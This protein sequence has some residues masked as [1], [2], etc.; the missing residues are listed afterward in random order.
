LPKQYNNSSDQIFQAL[1]CFSGQFGMGDNM[2]N[3]A[4]Y[5][6]GGQCARCDEFW[7]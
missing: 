7:G 4:G 3:N 6:V 1:Q 5:I 2:G